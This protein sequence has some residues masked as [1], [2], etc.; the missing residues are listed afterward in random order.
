[1]K[2]FW[3]FIKSMRKDYMRIPVSLKDKGMTVIDARAKADLLNKQFESV[4][5][6]EKDLGATTLFPPRPTYQKND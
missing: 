5:T 2:K 6:K 4:F 3:Q 1:M